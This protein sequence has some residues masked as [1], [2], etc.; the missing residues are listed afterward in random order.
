M[1]ECLL[2]LFKCQLLPDTMMEAEDFLEPS[3]VVSL[4][5]EELPVEKEDSGLIN[6]LVSFIVASS[7]MPRELSLSLIHI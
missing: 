7:E 4:V 6:S 3:G 5:R 1:T 2:Q